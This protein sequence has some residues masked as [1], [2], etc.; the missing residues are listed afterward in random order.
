MTNMNTN[1]MQDLNAVDYRDLIPRNGFVF[2]FIK[3]DDDY[4]H[5]F[6]EGDFITNMITPVQMVVGKTLFDFLP[7]EQAAHKLKFYKRAWNGETVNYEGGKDDVYYVASLNPIKINGV[8]VEVFGTAIDITEEKRNEAKI[9]E[10]EKLA[11][12]GELAAGIAHEVRNPLTSLMGFTQILQECVEDRNAHE[13]LGI[14][15]KELDKINNIVNDFMFIANPHETLDIKKCTMNSIISNM[16][17]NMDIQLKIKGIRIDF[18]DQTLIT[19]EC[20]ESLITQVL[21]NLIQNALE[22]T[23][24]KGEDIKISLKN[25]S[26]SHYLIEITDKGSGMTTDRL[27]RLY[28]PFYTT[29]EKGTGLGLMISRRIVDVHHGTIDFKSCIG[30]GTAV[31]ITLPKT[32]N[33]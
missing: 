15:M 23:K 24:E 22:A 25:I 12:V 31:K 4:I 8:V 20:D 10:L 27:K 19:A 11:V 33:K 6:V 7:K 26:E 21:M 1:G 29:K 14:M 16:I 32:L 18:D 13:Y 17:K 5:T 3:Q 9:Q 28:E 2:K 30:E